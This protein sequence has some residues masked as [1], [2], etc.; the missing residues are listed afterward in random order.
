MLLLWGAGLAGL[1]CSYTLAGRGVRAD[2]FE[3]SNRAGG[4]CH[5]LHNFF[6]EQ[7]AERGGE[8]IDTGHITM[9]G[10]AN[11]FGLTLED[12]NKEPGNITY[13]FNGRH[14]TEAQ[15][16]EE[17]RAFVP[18]MQADIT[19]L[20]SPTA[21]SFT[22]DDRA[23]D[24]TNLKDY[25]VSWGAGPLIR[26]MLDVAYTIEYGLGIEQQSCINL[27]VHANRR[28][29]FYPFGVF[30]DERFHVVQGNDRI[31]KGLADRLAGQIAYEHK[32]V[33]LRKLPDGHI[34]LTF[35]NAGKIVETEYY[36]VVLT[37][38][39]LVLRDVE[40]D[41]SL[42]L[43]DWKRY[44]IN[45]LGYGTNSKM[46]LGFFIAPGTNCMAV[47]DRL[48]VTGKTFKT[49]GKPIAHTCQR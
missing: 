43:P 35:N 14:S 40:L 21:T 23:L 25:L 12:V 7:V 6:P 45:N 27:L 44:A 13:F 9:R 15:M 10:Y 31:T 49:L 1:S 4:R 22:A 5:S 20:S 38:P 18:A 46:M 2:L 24:Y 11:A 8:F 28:S 34:R 47:M 26:A 16:V 29:K 39:F 42:G 41:V 36:A 33:K 37:L 19:K 30:S 3:A 48:I 17:F 32:L